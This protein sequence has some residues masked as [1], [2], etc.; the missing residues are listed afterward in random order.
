MSAR[1]TWRML[2]AL[3]CA[4]WMTGCAGGGTSGSTSSGDFAV[5]LA[6][7]PPVGNTT[8]TA[9]LDDSRIDPTTCRFEWRRNGSPIAEAATALLEP[10]RF[11]KGDLI[12]VSV[13]VSDPAG[14]PDRNA[15]ASARVA[16]SPP[17]ITRVTL[18]MNAVGASAD[19]QASVECADP[20]GENPT[21]EYQWIQNGQPIGGATG[22][23]LPA[24]RYTRGEA[25]AVE[26]VARDGESASAPFRSEPFAVD[27]HPPQFSSQPAPPKPADTQW[28]YR[29]Q[30]S[31]PDGDPLRYE[32]ISGP[33]GMT[34]DAEGQ[35]R[36]GLPPLDSRQGD[37]VVR[38]RAAD[39][40]GA[41]AVQEFT[42]RLEPVKPPK[43]QTA[44]RKP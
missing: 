14:G 37:Y 21:F 40:H 33:P 17:A 18:S 2:A 3:A 23:S 10:G 19:L 5:R 9:V 1:Q 24:A 42:L 26:V 32:L 39:P 31:D 6:P 27:N 4:A 28:A 29:A 13:S 20:D 30:A 22:A 15:K 44:D 35:V 25:V 7:D 12:E 43:D 34:I 11:K 41:E 16:N 38:L 36:W 8:V